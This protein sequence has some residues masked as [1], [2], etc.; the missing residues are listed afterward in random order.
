M[1]YW[2]KKFST[3]AQLRVFQNKMSVL[4]K[5]GNQNIYSGLHLFE[6]PSPKRSKM[7]FVMH[8]T[9]RK[10]EKSPDKPSKTSPDKP[11]PAKSVSPAKP[12]H[13]SP[14]KKSSPDKQSVKKEASS[15]KTADVS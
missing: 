10:A 9:E 12:S 11:S 4:D 13:V 6:Q 14:A 1:P 8:R 5:N 2:Q 15:D 7:E 3:K